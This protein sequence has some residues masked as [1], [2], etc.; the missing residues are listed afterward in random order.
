MTEKRPRGMPFESWVDKQIREADE[1]GEFENLPGRG[2]PLPGAGE[3]YDEFWWVKDKLRKEQVSNL[4][5]PLAIR[6][7]AEDA[8][9]DALAAKTEDSVREIIGA[10]NDR[11]REALHRPNDGPPLGVRPFEVE[12]VLEEWRSGHA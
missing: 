7:A 8:H 9:R 3:Q 11:I 5:G 1:R 4:P 2:R 6:K 12:Q 10:I